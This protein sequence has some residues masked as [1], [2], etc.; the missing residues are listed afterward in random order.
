VHD[1]RGVYPGVGEDM[2]MEHGCAAKLDGGCRDAGMG[3]AAAHG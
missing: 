2:P 3:R 1:A